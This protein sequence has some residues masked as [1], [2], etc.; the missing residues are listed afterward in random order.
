MRVLITEDD[1]IARRVLELFLSP[2]GTVVSVDR[3]DDAIVQ[4]KQAFQKGTPYSLIC[5]DIKLPG[6]PGLEVLRAIREFEREE[7]ADPV[8][9]IML[10]GSSEEG[11]IAEARALGA[12]KYLLKPIIEAELLAVLKHLTIIS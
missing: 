8:P 12:T 7:G 9:V 5:L 4:Y 11:E 3:G 2:H 6:K 10:T 1:A